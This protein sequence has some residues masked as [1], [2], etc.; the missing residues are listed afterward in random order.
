MIGYMKRQNAG[1]F[2]K[3]NWENKV[4]IQ[5]RNQAL[6]Q[7]LSNPSVENLEKLKKARAQLQKRQMIYFWRKYYAKRG[8]EL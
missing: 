7:K 8:V 4:N 5:E 1:W 6:K 3:S 2:N